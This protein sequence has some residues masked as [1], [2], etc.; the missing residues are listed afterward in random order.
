MTVAA[1]SS[2]PANTSKGAPQEH[3]QLNH[4]KNNLVKRL[5]K[6]L[7]EL[8]GMDLK[9]AQGRGSG[10][11]VMRHLSCIDTALHT[12]EVGVVGLGEMH[13]KRHD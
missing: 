6:M 2:S 1:S 4:V 8:E 5:A 10:A 9:F 12:A 7:S 3:Q 11:Q 13:L